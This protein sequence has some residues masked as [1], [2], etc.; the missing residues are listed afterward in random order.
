[1]D[2][3]GVREKRE[4]VRWIIILEGFEWKEV[5][6]VWEWKEETEGIR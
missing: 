4:E 2:S 3:K 6:E 5:L 1:M